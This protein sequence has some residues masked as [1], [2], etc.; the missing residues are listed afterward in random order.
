M[1]FLGV[2]GRS[3]DCH[4]LPLPPHSPSLVVLSLVGNDWGRSCVPWKSVGILSY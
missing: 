4:C 2:V 1:L 3:G